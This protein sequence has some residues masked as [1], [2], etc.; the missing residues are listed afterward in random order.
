MIDTAS[1][2]IRAITVYCASSN[3]MDQHYL[4]LAS[5]AGRAIADQGL[6]L[7]YGG[8]SVGMMGRAADAALAAGGRVR[9]I[10]TRDLVEYEVAH[11]GVTSLQIVET[12]HAR[13][14][15]MTGA[16][17]AFFVLP[18]GFGTLDETMEAIT[19]KQLRIHSRPIVIV[20]S[21]G[22][23]DTLL[24]FFQEAVDRRFIHEN[25]L[26]LFDVATTIDEAFMCLEN[27]R[28]PAPETDA[29]WRAPRP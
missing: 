10:I 3:A 22:Y 11:H 9:G 17:D 13:K 28:M 23:F 15:A 7:V 12:M 18:G 2:P 26:R 20:N 1:G 4:D 19:W 29:L 21:R 25:N 5:E 27:Q 24:Q 8:G 6:E 16:G 14:Q